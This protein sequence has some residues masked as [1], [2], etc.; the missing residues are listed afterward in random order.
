WV[1]PIDEII[2]QIV[3]GL[4]LCAILNRRLKARDRKGEEVVAGAAR[5]ASVH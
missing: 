3:I 5:A 4:A 2:Q 1:T